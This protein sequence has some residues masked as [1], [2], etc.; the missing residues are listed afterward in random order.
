[1]AW[2]RFLLGGVVL[3]FLLVS[4]VQAASFD[5]KKPT[6]KIQKV[7]C[8]DP[9]LNRLD[10]EVANAFKALLKL[11]PL[12]EYVKARQKEWQVL[13]HLC[14]DDYLK[15][16]L[17]SSYVSRLE[18]LIWSNDITVFSNKKTFDFA[19]ADAVVEINFNAKTF[20]I[21]GGFT[22]H[23]QATSESGNPVYVGC[24]FNGVLENANAVLA[25]STEEGDNTIVEFKTVGNQLFLTDPSED[26]C[27]DRAVL[28]KVFYRVR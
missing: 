17:K 3:P 20:M 13:N 4:T 10:T 5:C 21:W 6:D 22:E 1:M 14:E 8:A 9:E 2:I 25:T 23:T 26:I 11:H 18:E 16:C 12:P 19:K 24:Q 7:I 27:V 15:I 28:P